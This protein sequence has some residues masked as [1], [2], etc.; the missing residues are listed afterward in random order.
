MHRHLM[1]AFDEV[2]GID[3]SPTRIEHL[4][5]LDIPNVYAA[6]AQDFSLGQVFETI[7]AG[8]VIAHL[9][10]PG[11]FLQSAKRHLAPGGR[12]VISTPYVFG[13]EAVLYA[14]AKYPRTCPNPELMLWL[15]PTTLHHLAASEGFDVSALQMIPDDRRPERLSAYGLALLAE[16][17]LQVVLPQRAKSKTM[18]A[19]LEPSTTATHRRTIQQAAE[20]VPDESLPSETH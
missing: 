7:V 13:L 1:S 18:L 6:D 17:L 14:M 10:N 4:R 12:I 3:L 9:P 11:A 15:C 20:N 19:V 5:D 8:E 2:W 16:R